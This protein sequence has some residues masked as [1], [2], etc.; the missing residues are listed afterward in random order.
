M[1]RRSGAP[2]ADVMEEQFFKRWRPSSLIQRFART[3]EVATLVA[4]VTSP[5]SSTTT[6]AALRVDG[7]IV[8]SAF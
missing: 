7:G 2:S 8:R 1:V 5:L 4:Y 3:D 6:G